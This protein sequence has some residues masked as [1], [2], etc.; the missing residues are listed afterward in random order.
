MPRV[1]AQ[2]GV[3]VLTDRGARRGRRPSE[4]HGDS[5]VVAHK[6]ADRPGLLRLHAIARPRRSLTSAFVR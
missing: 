6:T 2:N 3:P 4:G 5:N 1:V